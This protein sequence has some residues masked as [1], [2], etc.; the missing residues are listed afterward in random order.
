M[1]EKKTVEKSGLP[2]VI[3]GVELTEKDFQCI[4][5]RMQEFIRITCMHEDSDLLFENCETCPHKDGCIPGLYESAQ[6]LSTI[7]G[8]VITPWRNEK[9]M[10]LPKNRG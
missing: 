1:E 3:N 10:L 5:R 6:K 8:V 7:T 9:G 4:T 2:I